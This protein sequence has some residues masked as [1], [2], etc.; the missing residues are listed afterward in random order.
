MTGVPWFLTVINLAASW[1][2]FTLIW[3]VQLII[4]PGF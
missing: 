4:Y 1:G 3:L 2:L